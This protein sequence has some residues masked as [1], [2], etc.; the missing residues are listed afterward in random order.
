MLEKMT[1]FGPPDASRSAT[2]PEPSAHFWGEISPSEHLVQIYKDDDVFLDSLEGFIA[3]GIKAG[4]G[5][6]VIATPAHLAKLE[7]RLLTRGI[8]VG[9][10]AAADQYIALDAKETLAKFMVDGPLRDGKAS[11]PDETLFKAVVTDLITRAGRHPD[12]T[13]RRVRAFGEMVALLWKEGMA[14]A[15]VR[16]EYLWHEYCQHSGLCL[17]CAYPRAYFTEDPELSIRQ[18]CAAHSKLVSGERS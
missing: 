11:W 6:V 17:F 7:H 16:L 3:G 18:I 12:G 15:T 2:G 5:V 10:A 14:A 13:Q 4:D 8:D 1:T 9:I